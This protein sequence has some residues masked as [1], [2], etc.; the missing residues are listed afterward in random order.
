MPK[1]VAVTHR[2]AAAFVDAEADLFLVEEP[3]GPDDRVLAGLSVAFDASCEEMWLAWR[4]GAC[5][6]PAPRSLVRTGM[7]LGPWLVAQRITIVS[8]V[9]TLAGLWPD[10]ALDQVRLLIF[11]GEAC[12]PAL[13]D[14]LAVP[15]R[16]VW[17]TYGPTEATVVACAA[18]L[19]VGEPVRIGL[20]LAGWDLAVVDAGGV[21]VGRGR[22]RRADH[23]RRG[24]GA[25]PGPRQ[26]RGAVRPDA[27]ARLGPRLSQ[28]RPRRAPPR[29]ACVFVGRAD[30]QVKVGG[31][32]IELGEIDA[33]L[34]ALPGVSAAAVS[35]AARRPPA[36]RSSWATSRPTD[37]GRRPGD[38]HR[39]APR[40]APRRA[41][42]A[43]ARWS[44]S[45]PTR[46][47]G[48]IDR[49]ALPWPL[50][51]TG[52][53]AEA[54]A[55]SRGRPRG[56]PRSGARCSAPRS[57]RPTTT[58]S[59]SGGGSLSAA[60]LVSRRLRRR[61]PQA[62]VADVYAYPRLA[63]LAEHLDASGDGAEVPDPEDREWVV[64]TS[65]RTQL[66][67]SVLTLGLQTVVGARWLVWLAL[68]NNLFGRARTT[69][70]WVAPVSWWW[71]AAGGVVLVTP[72]GRM[73]IAVV[74]A[75]LLLLGV[76]PGR[77]STRAA[78]RTC[79]SGPPT[80][81]STPPGR[82]T[83]PARRGSPPSPARWAPRSAGAS[84]CTACRR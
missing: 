31:R 53:G 17:N 11:G 57:R 40:V 27:R 51:G 6:V 3:I 13:V 78:R 30:E 44:T 18:R 21:P 59:S 38:G 75:R 79:G 4:N 66:L 42:T 72:L 48:K 33:A 32:R 73:A 77:P 20:P 1:G 14:R 81:S 82:P 71:V 28:R 55:G 56:W 83:W 10:D 74:G 34:Q 70:P 37:D 49:A 15:G 68:L 65:R 41:R 46:T 52:S 12:P 16:E 69:S 47:S 35:G 25:L 61:Y 80:G 60:Q 43:A 5:L 7:D 45:C 24:S 67:L 8:T 58:S 63:A 29:R 22:D 54:P 64:P 39:P 9:P 62:T 50:P 76:R 23:R 19:E 36:T 26:G 2:S 84:I